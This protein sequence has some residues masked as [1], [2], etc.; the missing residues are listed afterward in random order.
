MIVVEV[1]NLVTERR[2]EKIEWMYHC[3]GYG[4]CTSTDE[5]PRRA[6]HRTVLIWGRSERPGF[7][8]LGW[9]LFIIA[10]LGL[11]PWM[12]VSVPWLFK[13]QLHRNGEFSNNNGKDGEEWTEKNAAQPAGRDDGEWLARIKVYWGAQ[14]VGSSPNLTFVCPP[15]VRYL[16]YC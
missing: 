10:L 2:D 6:N 12:W 5:A 1:V 3:T 15:S 14:P 8:F 4:D 13:Y 16:F 9:V 11:E 7:L